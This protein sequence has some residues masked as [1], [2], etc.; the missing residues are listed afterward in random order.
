MEKIFVVY[1]KM[2]P[3]QYVLEKMP[4]AYFVSLKKCLLRNKNK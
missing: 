3:G 2:C 1:G 4:A